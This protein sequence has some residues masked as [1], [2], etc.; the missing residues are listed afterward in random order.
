MEG[1]LHSKSSEEFLQL[2]VTAHLLQL[3]I[4]GSHA[5]LYAL[6]RAS[7]ILTSLSLQDK[8]GGGDDKNTH[9]TGAGWKNNHKVL[10]P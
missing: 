7:Q 3:V 2:L 8:W 10:Q 1:G 5:P 4:P 6:S 9:I